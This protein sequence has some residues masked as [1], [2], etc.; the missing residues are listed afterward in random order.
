MESLVKQKR[1]LDISETT[2]WNRGRVFYATSDWISFLQE[3]RKKNICK[4]NSGVLIWRICTERGRKQI[5]AS[6]LKDPIWHSLEWQIES[7]SSEATRYREVVLWTNY[8]TEKRA[9][10]NRPLKDEKISLHQAMFS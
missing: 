6:E 10:F 9:F 7:F 2:I 8:R 5:V 1:E 4:K 3:S